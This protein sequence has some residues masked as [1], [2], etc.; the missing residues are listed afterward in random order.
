MLQRQ[1]ALNRLEGRIEIPI[2]WQRGSKLTA[3]RHALPT[4]AF[5]WS[6]SS[7]GERDVASP[8]ACTEVLLLAE[9]AQ[10]TLKTLLWTLTPVLAGV[11]SLLAWLLLRGPEASAC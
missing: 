5:H 10:A 2:S 6:R 1:W 3:A 4:T 9:S 11:W 8:F 7:R